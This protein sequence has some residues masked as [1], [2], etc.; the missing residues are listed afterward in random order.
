MTCANHTRLDTLAGLSRGCPA[1]EAYARYAAERPA[2]H[3]ERR[4]AFRAA[5][6]PQFRGFV[7]WLSG[8]LVVIIALFIVGLISGAI[9]RL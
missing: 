5:R 8:W 9:N 3:H 4:V 1:C 6:R 2:T 7:R